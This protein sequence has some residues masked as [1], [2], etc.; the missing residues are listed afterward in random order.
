ML[1][2]AVDSRLVRDA[3][4]QAERCVAK[5]RALYL[6]NTAFSPWLGSWIDAAD[7]WPRLWENLAADIGVLRCQK[8]LRKPR[9]ERKQLA[10]E[11]KSVM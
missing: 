2:A 5:P 3:E 1:S 9:E 4:N 8:W 7:P 6:Q 11:T 10:G